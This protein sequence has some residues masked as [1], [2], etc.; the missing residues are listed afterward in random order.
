ME[1][2]ALWSVPL[3]EG[4]NRGFKDT[5]TWSPDFSNLLGDGPV[6]KTVWNIIRCPQAS[7]LPSIN[8]AITQ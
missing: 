4:L 7:P 3:Q 6:L 5:N 1:P 8:N 2:W